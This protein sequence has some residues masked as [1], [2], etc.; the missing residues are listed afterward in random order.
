MF[1]IL[2]KTLNYLTMPLV[3]VCL[4]LLAGMIT[5]SKRWKP[6]LFRTGL[7]LLFFFTNDFIANEVLKRWEIPATPIAAID[8][9][10]E[11][12]IVLTGVTKSN[13]KPDDRVYF[14][15]GA[16]RVVHTLQLYKLGIVKKILVSG[17]SGNLTA[18]SRQEADELS[19]ALQLMG[20]PPSDILVENQSKNTNESA[21]AVAAMLDGTYTPEN[22][23]LV[24]SAFHMRR[25]IACFRKVGWAMDTYSTDF[26]SHERKFTPDSLI[27][28][29]VDGLIMWHTL[30]K[31]WTGMLAYKLAG[32]I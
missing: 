5:R 31:E 16:D 1:F 22:C 21:V 12:A 24:T 28:P 17:G 20:V 10:Y 15:R 6:R 18:R 13:M 25:S 32:Y 23:L 3:I 14:Q 11:L 9:K 27:I 29:R 19:E 4:L 8:K 30:I 2:S 7:F 26:I